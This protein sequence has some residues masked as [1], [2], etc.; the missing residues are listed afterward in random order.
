MIIK[1]KVY[2]EQKIEDPL[3]IELINS[4]G[5]QR[6]K[7]VGQ[8][9]TWRLMNP[10]LNTT[11]FE[12]S[13]GVYCLLKKFNA[14]FDEQIAGLLHDLNHTAFSHVID[15]VLGDPET[16]D[17]GDLK[18]KEILMNSTIPSILEK[19][20]IDPHKISD[21]HSFGLLER[22][23]PD[24]CCDRIDYCLRDSIC[25]GLI[26]QKKANQILNGLIVHNGEIICKDKNSAAEISKIFLHMAKVLW[27]NEI[28]SGSFLLLAK[29]IKIA[30]K[31]GILNEQNL[32]TTDDNLYSVLANS[33]NKEILKLIK[34]IDKERIIEGTKEDHDFHTKAKVRYIDPKFL[35]NGKLIRLSEVDEDYKKSC[36]EYAER[37]KKGF[38]IKIKK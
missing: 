8:Y 37:I 6:L 33:N 26:N 12:H 5:M 31:N 27:S 30:L 17:Y 20:N 36:Q 16:Q 11:R 32:Y 9:S 4:P 24:L 2:G 28:Q 23:L 10:K 18:H 21:H 3:I 1:D 15:Y 38:Y 34:P 7:G 22:D 14:S 19:R 35:E 25:Y 13:F 29:A